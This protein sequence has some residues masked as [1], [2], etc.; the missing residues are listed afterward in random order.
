M[1]RFKLLNPLT[2]EDRLVPAGPP[3]IDAW[4]KASPGEFARVMDER[5]LAAGPTVTWNTP[6]AGGTNGTNTIAALGDNQKISYSANNVYLQNPNFSSSVMGPWYID[7]ATLTPFP[8]YPSNQN[9]IFRIT[10]NPVAATSHTATALGAIGLGVNGVSYFNMQDGMS[11]SVATGTVGGKGSGFWNRDARVGEGATLDHALAH[12]PQSGEY[13][14]HTEPVALRAQLRDNIAFH[15]DA[16]VTF[17]S[18]P[19]VIV[20]PVSGDTDLYAEY[21]NE[22]HHSP[23]LGYALDGF[24]IYGPYGYASPTNQNS[25]IEQMTSS[26]RLRDIT[27][28]QSLP[29]FAAKAKFGDAVAFNA[30]GE[31]SLTAA[32]YGP[33]VSATYPLGYF[34]EDYEYVAGLG[35]LDMYNGRVTKTPE[36]PNGTFAYFTTLHS[37]DGDAVFP[38]NVGRQYYGVPNAAVVT[39]ITESVT[40]HFDIASPQSGGTVRGTI[41]F[42]TN[43]NAQR[44]ASELGYSNVIVYID[45]NGNGILDN[46]ETTAI[47]GLDGGYE[48]PTSTNGATKL[49]LVVPTGYTQTTSNPQDVYVSGGNAIFGVTVG[50]RV[51]PPTVTGSQ[52]NGGAAQRSRVTEASI[53]LSE[54]VSFPSGIANAFAVNRIGGG[55]VAF[56]AMQAGSVVTLTF[57]NGGTIPLEASGSVPDG[58]YQ[59][60]LV[61][62]NIQGSGGVLDGNGNGVAGDDAIISFHRL[63]GDFNGDATVDGSTDFS[64]FGTA[65]GSSSPSSLYRDFFDFNSDGVIDGAIDFVHFGA[66]FGS[67]I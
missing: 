61:A 64:Q 46:G 13:H 11:Y 43:G 51:L 10:R 25:A 41:F 3:I 39:S 37:D 20:T 16:L 14:Y 36:Y 56:S 65:F 8:N 52:I 31:Y 45:G 24:P 23:I 28:R 22:L 1:K 47:T 12:Q 67:T 19:N 2:L 62:A 42:D 40:T 7:P 9:R 32:N 21:T 60:T 34:I 63:F 48:I 53:T 17:P 27:V 55:S 59:I 4:L 15:G 66:R 29:G 54:P 38:Y 6:Q 49:R 30:N 26:F 58:R 57:T 35:T 50:L 44:D 33:A 5:Q 18:D